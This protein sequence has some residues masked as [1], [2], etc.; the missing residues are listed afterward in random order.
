MGGGCAFVGGLLVWLGGG[1]LWVGGMGFEVLC[2]RDLGWVRF[3]GFFAR[4]LRVKVGVG[5]GGRS[6]LDGIA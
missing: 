5:S 6:R 1:T 3:G 4:W 2:W